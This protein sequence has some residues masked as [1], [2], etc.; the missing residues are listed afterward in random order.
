MP[1]CHFDWHFPNDLP[2]IFALS[3][4]QWFDLEKRYILISQGSVVKRQAGPLPEW[5]RG[6]RS[7]AVAER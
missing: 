3:R 1:H 7:S 4:K 5:D 2:G 6:L